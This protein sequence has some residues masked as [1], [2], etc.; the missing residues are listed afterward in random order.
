MKKYKELKQQLTESEL[1]DGGALGGYPKDRGSRSAFSDYGVHRIEN[2]EQLQRIKAFLNA[3]TSREYLEPR[4]ALSL[5]RVKLNLVGLDFEFN[6]KV[7]I[8]FNQPMIF[9]LTRYGGTFGTSPQHD[10]SKG[11]EVTDGF[12]GNSLSLIISINEAE[13]GLYKMDAKLVDHAKGMPEPSEPSV[14]K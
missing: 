6:K 12:D 2:K 5:L 4:S 11:F 9:K 3:F 13:S 8:L 1:Q 7:E 10:L 14:E